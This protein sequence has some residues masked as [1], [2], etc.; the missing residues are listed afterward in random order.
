VGG[1]DG[2]LY[3]VTD[4]DNDDPVNP[5]PSTLRYGVSQE[6]PLWIIF[7]KDMVINLKEELFMNS[8]KTIDGRGQNIQI[9]DG[10]CVTI[11]NVS[12]I[13]IHNIYIHGCV[14]GGNVVVSDE[15]RSEPRRSA[16]VAVKNPKYFN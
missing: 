3:V 15:P 8:H 11:R 1:R 12:N 10:P 13:I 7:D 5:I 6:E 2:N 16:R 4:S 9:A 14:P